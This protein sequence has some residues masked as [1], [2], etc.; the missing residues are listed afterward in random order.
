MIMQYTVCVTINYDNTKWTKD[1]I[2]SMIRD[3]TRALDYIPG[4][5]VADIRGTI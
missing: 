4:I 5:Y 1:E 2:K 3:S